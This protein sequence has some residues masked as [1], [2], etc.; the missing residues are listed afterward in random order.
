M[1]QRPDIPHCGLRPHRRKISNPAQP[2]QGICC[3]P[4]PHVHARSQQHVFDRRLALVQVIGLALCSGEAAQGRA[5]KG[6]LHSLTG[7]WCDGARV[8]CPRGQDRGTGPKA[9]HHRSTGFY[10]TQPACNVTSNMYTYH[11]M[12]T[13]HGGRE[14]GE[15]LEITFSFWPKKKVLRFR[16]HHLAPPHPSYL[17]GR[18]KRTN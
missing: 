12:T 4:N 1:Q 3:G 14:P 11:E 10:T 2:A 6:H 8:A 13:V 17:T 18:S 9:G 5:Q 16:R 7:T 15:L